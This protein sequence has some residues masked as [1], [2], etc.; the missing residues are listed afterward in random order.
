MINKDFNTILELIQEFPDEITCIN[1]LEAIR[2]NGNV[3][4]PFDPT[5]IVYVCKGNKYKCKN[6]GKYFNVKTNTLFDNTK[7][8]LQ[9]WFLAIWLITSLKK[10]ISSM[11]LAKDIGTTQKTAWFMLQRIRNCFG[12]IGSGKPMDGVVEVD[13]T[14]IGG[15]EKNKHSNKRTGRTQGGAG[16]TPIV[17]LLERGKEVKAKVVENTSA[18]EL[19][20]VALKNLPPNTVLMTDQN[21]TYKRLKGYYKYFVVNHAR[22]EYVKQGFIHTNS[23]EGF[24]GLFKRSIIGVYHYASPKHLQKHIDEMSFRYNTRTFGEGARL[25]Q[26]LLNS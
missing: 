3:V 26:L 19:L 16:K 11:Q 24:W 25:N 21:R 20:P 18:K 13:E 6:T 22:G 17:G 14:Y 5:S 15:K 4:S 7:V 2:W 8:K 10:G 23:L 1:H 9:K 12:D